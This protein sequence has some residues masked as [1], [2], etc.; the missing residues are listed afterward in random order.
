MLK[1]GVSTD[2]VE[3]IRS[4]LSGRVQQTTANGIVSDSKEINCGVPQGSVLGPLLF[5]IYINSI[6]DSIKNGKYYLYADDL[7]VVVGNRDPVMAQQLLQADLDS[8]GEWCNKYQLTINTAKTKVLWCYSDRD[9]TDYSRY[10]LVMKNETLR[11]VSHFTYLGVIVDCFLSLNPQ[12]NK[13]ISS[14][15]FRLYQLRKLKKYIDQHLSL[16]LYKQMVLPIFDYGDV[17][18]DSG[19]DGLVGDIQIL[20]NHCLRACIGIQDPQMISRP[21]LHTLCDCSMLDV[22]RKCN[23]LSR[24]Y[25]LSRDVDNTVVPVRDLRGNSKIKIKVQRPKCALYKHSPL[26]RGHVEWCKL[27][28]EDQKI[29]SHDMCMQNIKLLNGLK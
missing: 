14:G 15:N 20:Q 27:D 1:I 17:M 23:L 3:W 5:V 4:Y 18:T 10:N 8:I 12:C 2:A 21:D 19:S 7:A 6:V 13:I 16:L 28:A 22:R 29:D 9:K 11:V 26:Y 24:M 25:H